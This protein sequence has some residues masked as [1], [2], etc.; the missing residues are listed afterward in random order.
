M[1]FLLTLSGAHAALGRFLEHFRSL[2]L[3]GTRFYLGWHF[4][5][6]GWLKV[7]A[8]STTVELFRGSSHVPVLSPQ[9]AAL[10]AGTIELFLAVLLFLGLFSRAG[11]L[12]ALVFN[13]IALMLFRQVLPTQGSEAAFGQYVLWGFML[14]MLAVVGP[15]R[16]AVDTLLERRLA[17]RC[18]PFASAL[19]PDPGVRGEGGGASARASAKSSR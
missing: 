4:W 2:V 17:A 1:P 8:W 15:G 11:A 6:S 18:R 13:A 19:Q 14:L 16:I 9:I 5:R 7:S 12:G 3:L 10:T